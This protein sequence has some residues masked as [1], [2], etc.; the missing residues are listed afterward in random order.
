MSLGPLTLTLQT[1]ALHMLLPP[2][3]RNS[4]C[5]AFACRFCHFL[6]QLGSRC[7]N[8]RPRCNVHFFLYPFTPTVLYTLAMTSCLLFTVYTVYFWVPRGS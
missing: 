7:L 1:R 6:P 4:A 5:L 2:V 8:C 3:L